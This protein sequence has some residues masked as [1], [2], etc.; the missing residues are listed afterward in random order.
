M[1]NLYIKKETIRCLLVDDN[2]IQYMLT[3]D[4]LQSANTSYRY[5]VDWVSNSK[6]ALD[7]LKTLDYQVCLLDYRL[8]NEN[9]IEVLKAIRKLNN[10]IPVLIITGEEGPGIDFEGMKAGATDFL[11][12]SELTPS[13]LERAIRY[14]VNNT[15]LSGHAD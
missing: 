13:K 3:E 10:E 5:V 12:K 7:A 8:D 14:A 11:H 9:G 15:K 6:S 4:V 2:E 1:K